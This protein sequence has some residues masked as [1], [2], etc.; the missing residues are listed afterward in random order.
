MIRFIKSIIEDI[1]SVFD[2]DPAARNRIEVLLL[3]PHMKALITYRIA[4]NLY[5]KKRFFMARWISNM[6]RK[7]SGIEIHPGATIGKGLFI[8]HGMG[9]VIG[10][11]AVIGNNVTMFHGATL[12]GTGNEKGKR[13]PT[14]G[15][16]V[17]I[18]SSAKILGNIYIASGTKVGANS[19]V[20]YDTS[21]NST[22]VGIPGREVKKGKII[23]LNEYAI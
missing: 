17:T 23:C 12:G 22:V 3:Y 5:K 13:H 20:L 4:H 19:V 6:G 11:T 2:R 9:V 7:W 1:D 10:E 16:N 14:V 15:D 8:D 21:P 18:G